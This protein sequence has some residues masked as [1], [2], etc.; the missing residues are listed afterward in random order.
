M[1]VL[2]NSHNLPAALYHNIRKSGNFVTLRLEGVKSNRDA[3][4][5]L[6]WVT[7]GG[8][9]L[10]AECRLASSYASSSDK[11]LYFGLGTLVIRQVKGVK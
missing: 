6:V 10:F 5:A 1:D 7:A 2:D 3:V 8:R 11:R 4:G 9:R